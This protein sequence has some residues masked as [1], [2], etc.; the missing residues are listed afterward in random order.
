M[1]RWKN[2]Y[3]EKRK[4][5]VKLVENPQSTMVILVTTVST[6]VLK[7]LCEVLSILT[8]F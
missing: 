3:F 5:C 7:S 1:Y 2:K 8:P 6:N 4:K